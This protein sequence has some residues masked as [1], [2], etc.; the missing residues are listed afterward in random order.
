MPTDVFSKPADAPQRLILAS[1]VIG[2]AIYDVDGERIG[3]IDDVA[4]DKRDGE[5]AYAIA[6]VGDFLGLGGKYSPIPWSKLL[7]DPK[8]DGYAVQLTHDQLRK[9]P[10]YGKDELADI[11]ASQTW[12][13]I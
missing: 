9:A 3:H 13:F 6:A 2:L 5:I 7:Y 1:K 11:G 8:K 12:V 10:S 4:I